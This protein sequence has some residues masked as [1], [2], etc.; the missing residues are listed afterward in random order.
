MMRA[1]GHVDFYPAGGKHQP[2]CTDH[3]DTEG[4]LCNTDSI[5]DL[6]Q[7]GFLSPIYLP[8]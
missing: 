6:I 5:N 3:C 1:I 2:G 7:Y 8:I 4:D